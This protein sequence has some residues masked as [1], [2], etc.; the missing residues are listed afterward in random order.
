MISYSATSN[1]FYSLDFVQFCTFNATATYRVQVNVRF[2]LEKLLKSS[3]W[4]VPVSEITHTFYSV[5]YRSYY[6]NIEYNRNKIDQ[7]DHSTKLQHYKYNLA[8]RFQLLPH[9][10]EVLFKSVEKTVHLIVFSFL[11][12]QMKLFILVCALGAASAVF[13]V[14]QLFEAEWEHFKVI[15]H[16]NICSEKNQRSAR[17]CPNRTE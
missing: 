17:R 8:T 11:F 1:V 12:E 16:S 15:L 9:L 7:N 4:I 14:E 6:R 2:L 10:G 13:T 3:L 5:I